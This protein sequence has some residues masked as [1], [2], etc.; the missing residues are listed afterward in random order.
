MS[1]VPVLRVICIVLG[2]AAAVVVL[3][4][5]NAYDAPRPSMS[6]GTCWLHGASGPVRPGKG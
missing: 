4:G 1:L 2:I 3:R 6:R 5:R